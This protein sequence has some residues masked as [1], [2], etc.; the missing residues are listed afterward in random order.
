MKIKIWK[1]KKFSFLILYVSFF[2]FSLHLWLDRYFGV[3]DIEQFLFFFLLGF[4]GLLDTE[5]YII[6]KFIQICLL[7]PFLLILSS[8][9][10]FSIIVKI[11]FININKISYI[12]K[13]KFSFISI[14][15]FFMSVFLILK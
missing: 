14:F 4:E 6:N 3:V 12:I 10:L 11:N 7:L 9:I 5:D 8:Y 2:L 1:N 13:K 15:F